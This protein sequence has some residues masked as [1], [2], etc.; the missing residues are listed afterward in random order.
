MAWDP[1]PG[2]IW[3]GR[4]I[5]RRIADCA[6]R[7]RIVVTGTIMATELGRWRRRPAFICRLDDDTG[8]LTLVFGR[9]MPVPGM[10]KGAICTVEATAQSNG[11]SL[12]LW[13]PFYRFEP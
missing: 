1:T 10:V 12:F 6:P 9:P 11:G 7:R 5:A 4:P 3:G 2:D 13:D 8:C